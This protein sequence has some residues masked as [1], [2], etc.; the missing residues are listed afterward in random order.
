MLPLLRSAASHANR[1]NE[2]PALLPWNG[3]AEDKAS[4]DDLV[5]EMSDM[6]WSTVA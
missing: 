5:G 6:H 2:A 4:G 1:T 3:G